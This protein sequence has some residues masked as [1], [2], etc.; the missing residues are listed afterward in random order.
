[1]MKIN[2]EKGE[3][4]SSTEPLLFDGDNAK[5]AIEGGKE[6]VTFANL[7]ENPERLTK[8]KY[9]Q[10]ALHISSAIKTHGT[11]SGEDAVVGYPKMKEIISA[12]NDGVPIASGNLGEIEKPDTTGSTAIRETR[13]KIVAIENEEIETP[14]QVEPV[15]EEPE[16]S[17]YS[18]AN[19]YGLNL[20]IINSIAII[21]LAA[22]VFFK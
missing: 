5:K 14:A 17:Y 19:Y 11:D 15:Y 6:F 12:L 8:G 1:M 4:V 20:T 10:P 2:G 21:L 13:D 7:N 18:S 22:Y 9:L 3:E 16:V